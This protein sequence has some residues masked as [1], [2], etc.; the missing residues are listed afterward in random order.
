MKFRVIKMGFAELC[1]GEEV[2]NID[3]ACQEIITHAGWDSLDQLRASIRKWSE[4][5]KPG[6]VFKTRVSAVVAT[7]GY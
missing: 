6:S 2:M 1:G 7:R 4:N 5:A 3:K